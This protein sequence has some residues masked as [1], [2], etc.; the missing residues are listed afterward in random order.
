MQ[1]SLGSDA[2]YLIPPRLLRLAYVCQIENIDVIVERGYIACSYLTLAE[3]SAS[4]K[5]G[6]V[7]YSQGWKSSSCGVAISVTSGFSTLQEIF[8]TL[9]RETMARSLTLLVLLASII[10]ANGTPSP[11]EAAAAVKSSYCANVSRIATL[12]PGD[13][14]Y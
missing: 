11:T 3:A 1:G 4:M 2:R 6:T 7:K 10:R 8:H 13:L 12:H 5:A 9:H 14:L